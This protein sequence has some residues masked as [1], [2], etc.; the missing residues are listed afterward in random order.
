MINNHDKLLIR[1]YK[2][3][4]IVSLGG[5]GGQN[6][7]KVHVTVD[8]LNRD[9]HCPYLLWRCWIEIPSLYLLAGETT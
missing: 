8:I 4:P 2:K 9:F 6:Q 3:G 5:G 1:Y 7:N